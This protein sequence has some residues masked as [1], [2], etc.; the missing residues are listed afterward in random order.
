LARQRG[1]LVIERE[2]MPHQLTNAEEGA[3]CR[4]MWEDLT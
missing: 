2:I 1:I 3:I 4:L